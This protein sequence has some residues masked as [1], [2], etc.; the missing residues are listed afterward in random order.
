MAKLYNADISIVLVLCPLLRMK[1]IE[2]QL[3]YRWLKTLGVNSHFS[4]EKIEHLNSFTPS[5]S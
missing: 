2:K 4:L 5:F 3:N 1:M